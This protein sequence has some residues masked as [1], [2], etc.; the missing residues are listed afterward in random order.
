[1]RPIIKQDVAI[2]AP[3][4]DLEMK[5]AKDVCEILISNSA[6]I[7]SLSLKAVYFSFENIEKFDEG[8]VILIAKALLAM[9]NK[10]GVMVAFI[11]YDDKQ[12]QKLK[13]LFPNKS[14]PLFRTE[15]MANILLGVKLPAF[16]Q[17]II[18]YDTDQIMQTLISQ[19]LDAKGANVICTHTP[20]DFMEKKREYLEKALYLYDIYFDVTGNFIPVNISNGVVVYTLGKKVDKSIS[21]SFNTQAHNSRLRE[22]YR[23]F[24]FNA[25]DTK[26]FNLAVLDFIM[27]LALNNARFDAYIAICGLKSNIDKDKLCLCYRSHIVFFDSIEECIKDTK[28]LELAKSYQQKEKN[29]KGL[30]KHLV[31]QL[32]IFI[33]ASIETL[34][35]LTGGEAKKTDYKVTPYVKTNEQDIM[36]A[37]ISFEGDITGVVA[38]SFAKSL[39]KEASMMLLGE[40]CQSDEELLDVISEFTNI[41]AGR[42]KAILAEH[43]ISISISLPKAC[44]N[45]DMIVKMLEGKQGVQINLLLNNK[46]L[47]LFLAH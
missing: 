8:A 29:R 42:S 23:A 40:E 35:S 46:P 14:L 44:K 4:V 28:F 7:R 21:F 33:N 34:S 36:G 24:I 15:T 38:L 43:H 2:Y 32:P 27:S 41:I 30:T 9:Q 11:G 45:E 47:I 13:V 6:T 18:Y 3:Q 1:M 25:S 5:Q 37:M 10:V 20:Q 22:G 12:F 31:A 19:E 39:V 16:N 26:E 17:T